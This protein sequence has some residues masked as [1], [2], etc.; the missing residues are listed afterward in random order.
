MEPPFGRILGADEL[1]LVVVPGVAFDREG[2][3]I[4]YG[5]GYYDRLLGRLGPS[6]PAV[7][8][9]F[10]M[11]VVERVP[12]GGTDRRVDAIVTEDEVLR[13]GPGPGTRPTG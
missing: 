12:S 5:R 4:G 1:D 9:A 3:R 7:A 8:V 11:Q 13:T 10:G 2:D 6:V